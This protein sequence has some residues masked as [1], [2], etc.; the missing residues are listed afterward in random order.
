MKISFLLFTS[1]LANTRAFQVQETFRSS[2]RTFSP[3]PL[4]AYID[5]GEEVERDV[6]AMDEWATMCEVQRAEGFQLTTEDGYDYSALTTADIPEGS[7]ILCIPGN[8]IISTSSVRAELGGQ[9]A[10][11]DY[12]T[13]VGSGDKI[14]KFFVFLKIM[15]EYEQGD[16]SPYFPWLNSLPRLFFNAIAM[17]DFCYECLPPLV[18]QLA[19]QEKVKFDNYFEALQKADCISDQMKANKAVARWAYNIATTRTQGTEEEKFLAPMADMF[20]HGTETEVD[21]SFDD[22]G[23][24]YA[25]ATKNVPAGS[26]LRMSYGCPTNPSQLFAKYG[27]LDETSPATFCKIMTITPTQQLLDIGYGFDKMLFYKDS[28]EV[29]EEVWDVLL[30]QALA[31]NRDVQQAFYNAHMQGD[32]ATKAAIHQ[33]YSLETSTALMKHVDTFLQQLDDLQAKSAG[34][35]YNEHPRLP[36]ILK[37]NEF[38]RETFLRVKANLD[39]M[40]AQAQG[41]VYA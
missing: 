10:A 23:N 32:A 38:V 24:L 28:G 31:S 36:L 18:F 20:N 22:D 14:G 37:H 8:M 19:R 7:P 33:Q 11:V 25:Y 17:T 41:N 26:P 39:P 2:P 40:V 29:S 3:S 6:G 30:Y 27:F 16:Q 13:R 21:F 9:E 4:S 15:A 34:K 1:L 5:I 35:D 12:L